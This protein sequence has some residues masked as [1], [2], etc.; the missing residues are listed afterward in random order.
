MA[1]ARRQR[2]TQEEIEA[3]E[4][5]G[6]AAVELKTELEGLD[7]C[8][9]ATASSFSCIK[10]S[11]VR[12]GALVQN[13][14]LALSNLVKYVCELKSFNELLTETVLRRVSAARKRLF[15]AHHAW[16]ELEGPRDESLGEDG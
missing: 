6:H 5:V 12:S 2:M 11:G 9:R 10:V 1:D 3:V 4:K 8:R 14:G 13:E 15:D 16:R 7:E